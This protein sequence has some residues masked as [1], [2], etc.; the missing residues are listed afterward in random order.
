MPYSVSRV[1]W[2]IINPE[3]VRPLPQDSSGIKSKVVRLPADICTELDILIE[4]WRI[5]C[6]ETESP[7]YYFARILLDELESIFPLPPLDL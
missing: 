1:H 7:R 4:N 5:A 2:S 3:R 6:D